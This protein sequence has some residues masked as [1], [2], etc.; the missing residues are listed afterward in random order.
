MVDGRACRNKCQVGKILRGGKA[1]KRKELSL[2]VQKTTC[3]SNLIE[4][5]EKTMLKTCFYTPRKGRHFMSRK[6]EVRQLQSNKRWFYE[7]KFIYE[8]QFGQGVKCK[9]RHMF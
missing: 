5:K 8:K 7:Q 6:S 9:V 1:L 2:K 4:Q 3:W